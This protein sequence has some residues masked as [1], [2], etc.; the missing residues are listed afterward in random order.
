MADDYYA[1]LGVSKSASKDEIRKAYKKLA[2]EFH[3]DVKPDDKAAAEKF[4]QIQEA[5]AVLS[6][7]EKRQQYDQYGRV[8]NGAGPFP[9]G[10]PFEGAEFDLGDLFGGLFG[11]GGGAAGSPF[12]GARQRQP[13]PSNGQDIRAEI[14]VPF[15]VAMQG[16]EHE[17]TLTRGS[18]RDRLSVRIP[19]GVSDGQAIRLAGQGHPG[20]HGGRP[21]NVIVTVRVAEH[22]WF[23]REGNNLI[24]EVPITP[25]EAALGAKVEVPTLDEGNL[26]LTVPPGTSGG[27]RLRLRGK[28]VTDARTKQRGDELVVI[29]IAVP[30]ELS[31]TQRTLY[32]QLRELDGPSPRDGLWT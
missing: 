1:T 17:I 6:D 7:D 21:G 4:K 30:V 23:R 10:N 29:K 5:Y 12:G 2:R 15:Q 20:H 9:G 14:T 31:E 3:P 13:R 24:V 25:A 19:A 18:N 11:Q 28:G 16:G 22:P 27:A 32:E 8:F 26:V